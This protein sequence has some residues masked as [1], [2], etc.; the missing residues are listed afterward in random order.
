MALTEILVKKAKVQS[1]QYQLADDEGLSLVIEPSGNK[2]WKY[3]YS[4]AHGRRSEKRLGHFPEVTLKQARQNRD[5]FQSE[6]L[7]QSETESVSKVLCFRDVA[8]EWLDFKT[9][10]SLGD[11]PR[12]GVLQLAKKCIEQE[13]NPIIGDL[14][15]AELKRFDLVQVIRTIES[16]GVKEPVKKACSYLN[17]IF[18]YAVAVGYIEFN[19]A[20]QLHKVLITTK[21]KIN[22]PHLKLNEIPDFIMRINNKKS[23]PMIKKALWLKLYSGVRGAEL[24][25]AKPE[26]FDLE[27][28]LWKIPAIHVKQLRRKVLLGID[29]PDYVIPL[30]EQAV[31]VVR[32]AM[33]WSHGEKYVFSSPRNIDK[34][35]HINA[36]NTFIRKL[37]YN[38]NELSSHGLRSTMSTILNDS[39]LFKSEWIEAQLSH[40]DKNATRGSY[41]HADYLEHRARMMQWWSDFLHRDLASHN[42]EVTI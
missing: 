11:Y 34:H 42:I 27:K 39:G 7:G 26:H 40:T 38:E 30:S 31:E 18:D 28:R 25:S 36:I 10:N 32:S 35:I 1:K 5:Q 41:N 15:F 3:R 6:L 33:Q 4:N 14:P 17:Q 9:R 37:G 29:V 20:N 2:Y 12:C 13:L 19:I 24:I 8:Q 16:R 21:V 23:H 22:Y